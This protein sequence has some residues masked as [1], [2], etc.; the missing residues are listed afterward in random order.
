MWGY[1]IPSGAL[2]DQEGSA[3]LGYG[4]SGAPPLGKNNAAMQDTRDV[5]PIP[6]GLYTI[7]LPPQCLSDL[8]GAPPRI[9]VYCGGAGTH[10]HGP[11]VLRLE[12]DPENEMFDRDGFLIHGDSIEHPGYA[13]KGCIVL[14]RPIREQIAQSLDQ[15]LRVFA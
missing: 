4:Y 12:A 7:H 5:G 10:K 15:R 8:S 6:Q 14:S 11:F 2:F 13:S 9:C 3:P 1:S